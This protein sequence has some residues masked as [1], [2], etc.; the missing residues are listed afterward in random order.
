TPD[1]G[2]G[3]I[4][5]QPEPALPDGFRRNDLRLG[6]GDVDEQELVPIEPA[7]GNQCVL[8]V[9]QGNYVERQVGGDDVCADGGEVPAVGQ[10]EARFGRPG[11]LGAYGSVLAVNGSHD[12]E[13]GEQG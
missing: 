10:E 6:S 11:E 13:S 7:G 9:L 3:P 12:D 4:H 2:L 5:G 8:A 1:L